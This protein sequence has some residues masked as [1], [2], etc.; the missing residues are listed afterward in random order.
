ME[1]HF[2]IHFWLLQYIHNVTIVPDGNNLTK[3]KTVRK[4]EAEGM[5]RS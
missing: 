4:K 5:C 1:R 3:L 2:H